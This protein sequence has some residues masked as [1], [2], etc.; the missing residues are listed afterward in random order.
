VFTGRGTK[1]I[2]TRRTSLIVDPP[3][4][5]IP[6]LTAPRAAAGGE[7][8][9]RRRAS[10]LLDPDEASLIARTGG[11]DGP[12]DRRND[13]CLGVTVPFVAGTSGSFRRLV[14][15]PGAVSLFYEDGHRGG[16]YRTV[17]LD[18]RPHLPPS[19]R[20]WAG[21]SVGRW[22]GETL[23]VDTTNFSDQ[24]NFN[25][26]REKLHLIE[27]YTRTGPDLL[28]YRVTIDDPSAF[29]SQWTIELPLTR[30]DDKANSIYEAACHEGNHAMVGIL[31]GAR[32]LEKEQAEK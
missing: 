18:G 22:E 7:D 26:S 4:G 24:T 1:V 30:I 17:H 8:G 6:R 11:F 19:V 2:R 28:M 16:T 12:E 32:A 31:A 3:D 5:R 29:A 10:Y 27:R 23:V 15:A 25:G 20:Q 21:H 13:R 9:S 14:Q